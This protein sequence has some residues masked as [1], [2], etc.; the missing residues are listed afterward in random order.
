MLVGT[1]TVLDSKGFPHSDIST[2]TVHKTVER[3]SRYV[4]NPFDVNRLKIS[5]ALRTAI[6][7]RP[8]VSING[9]LVIG[10][11]FNVSDKPKINFHGTLN[12]CTFIMKQ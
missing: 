10:E 4:R 6:Y 8:K 7:N 1:V 12:D 5:Y 11:S 9:N 2:V 3:V